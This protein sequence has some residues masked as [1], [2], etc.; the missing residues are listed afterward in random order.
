[1]KYR[2]YGTNTYKLVNIL[3]FQPDLYV[4]EVDV[5]VF[6]PVHALVVVQ[7]AQ[8]VE[9]LVRHQS[10]RSHI[11]MELVNCSAFKDFPK[12]SLREGGGGATH[13]P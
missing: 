13:F 10:N 1:M 5:D 3:L 2:S 6:V 11:K 4:V 12:K 9:Q 7:D 8:G